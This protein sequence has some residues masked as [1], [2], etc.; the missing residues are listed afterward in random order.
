MKDLI[1]YKPQ[2]IINL[3]Y[4]INRDKFIILTY[5]G[6]IEVNELPEKVWN[7]INGEHTIGEIVKQINK[8]YKNIDQEIIKKDVI[9]T[10]KKF[11][12]LELIRL[13]WNYLK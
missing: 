8:E 7:Y 5:K 2:K 1:N 11:S 10:L 9:Q 12:D 13:N 3:G 6:L 4:W